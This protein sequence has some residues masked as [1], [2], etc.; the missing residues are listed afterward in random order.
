M[1]ASRRRKQ[2]PAASNYK[3]ASR[4]KMNERELIQACQKGDR[5][6]FRSLFESYQDQ[7]FS[8]AMNY[9]CDSAQAQDITQE[10][11]LKLYQRLRQFQHDASFSTWLYRI[12]VNTC[13]NEQR[14]NRRWRP[15]EESAREV[16]RSDGG[17]EHRC[18]G[19]E[20]SLALQRAVSRLPPELRMLVLLRY[21]EGLS[22]AE[23]A[24]S[25]E[26]SIGTVSSRLSRAHRLLG[27]QL[28][29]LR[30]ELR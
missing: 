20:V 26:C 16:E 13:L 5:G 6:A 18:H 2:T 24:S 9:C 19:N 15:L 10:V 30:E 27:E 22:Y 28:S 29:H 21:L 3:M 11:F 1:K 4:A 23:I 8:L 25:L 14:R 7:V 12:V 17:P